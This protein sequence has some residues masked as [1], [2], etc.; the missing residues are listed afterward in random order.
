M[1]IVCSLISLQAEKIADA[2]LMAQFTDTQARVQ[3]MALIHNF[4]YKSENFS[5]ISL[6]AYLEP[7]VEHLLD[8]Y[9]YNTKTV[10]VDIRAHDILLKMDHAVP[11]GL[12]AVELIS[13]TLKYAIPLGNDLIITIKADYVPDRHI[14]MKIS[15]NGRKAIQAFKI[16]NPETLG[17]QI[18]TEII[19]G[20]LEGTYQVDLSQGVAWT[21]KWAV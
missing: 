6:Q 12:I 10:Q 16:S 9:K 5:Q 14:K 3:S 13:N 19:C 7:L 8:A 21:I 2:N 20:Q 1:Q 11:C 15:D 18:V 17:L 4:L